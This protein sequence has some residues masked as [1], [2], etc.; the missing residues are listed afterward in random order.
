MATNHPRRHYRRP[1]LFHLSLQFALAF[2][3]AAAAAS[4]GSPSPC[5][6]E[7]TT[8][9]QPIQGQRA[10][11]VY[12]FRDGDPNNTKYETYDW[13][14]VST[15]AWTPVPQLVCHAHARGARVVSQGVDVPS[16]YNSKISRGDF[17][18]FWGTGRQG[19][20]LVIEMPTLI[21]GDWYKGPLVG[22]GI[23]S[24][25]WTRRKEEC[26]EGLLGCRPHPEEN[27][28]GICS[29]FSV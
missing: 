18:W 3:T 7:N 19:F 20:L 12:G 22:C 11:E 27:V 15:V 21:L 2:V 9:C 4:P 6:C 23:A 5:P 16:C 8:L 24:S 13:D 1:L 28:T 14:V 26:C 29:P 10:K 25:L 17:V